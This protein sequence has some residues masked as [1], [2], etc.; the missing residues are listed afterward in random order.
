MFRF[1][2]H[3]YLLIAGFLSLAVVMGIGRFA[4]TPIFPYMQAEELLTPFSAGLLAASNYTGYFIGA[5]TA[6]F[7]RF[8]IAGIYIG[9]ALNILTTLLMGLTQSYE[10]W[11]L[12]RLIS[13]I[14]SGMVF[15]FISNI[16][17]EKLRRSDSTQLIGWLF[18][19]VGFG[20]LLSGLFI[21]A[22][23]EFGGW[24]GSW[25]ALAL[26]CLVMTIF[27]IPGIPSSPSTTADYIPVEKKTPPVKDKNVI[28]ALYVSYSCEGF[29]YIIFGTF[30]TALLA[31]N[32]AFPFPP[33]YVWA[34]VGLGAIPS[35]LFWAWLGNTSANLTALKYAYF[36]QAVSISIPVF[37]DHAALILLAAF[38]FGSTFMGI[39]MLTLTIARTL[40]PAGSHAVSGLT[41]AYALGQLAGPAVAGILITVNDY[42]LA[43]IVSAAV[44]TIAF[45]SL[46]AIKSKEGSFTHAVRKY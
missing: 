15:V 18:G 17:L 44:I 37:T 12:L 42:L 6:R 20:I 4:Y 13:G 2:N 7:V 22:L 36:V 3:L 32:A 1:R 9:L 25:L 21:P 29:G 5:W 40:A 34:V 19:G 43:F 41:S 28:R 30:I 23:E 8:P 31:E 45:V 46:I 10:L 33:S 16:V 39:T 26:L 35:C 11:S 27:I 14:T 24:Q 38:G